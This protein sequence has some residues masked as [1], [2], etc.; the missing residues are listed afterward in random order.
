M[1]KKIPP[2]P[3]GLKAARPLLFP[4]P[5]GTLIFGSGQANLDLK[6]NL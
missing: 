1:I 4:P 6:D 2:N 3:T 5:L